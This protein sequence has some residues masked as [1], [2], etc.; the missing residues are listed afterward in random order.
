MHTSIS[1]SLDQAAARAAAL[2]A[3]TFQ[4]FSSS[5]RMWR[6]RVLEPEEIR[7]LRQLR[8]RLELDPFVIHDNYLINLAAADPRIRERS[9]EAF[10]GELE[11]ALAL[12]A[13]YLVLHP[14]SYRGQSLDA[15]LRTL[16]ESLK[17]AARGLR[18]G[19]LTLLVENTA[20][21]G[22]ALGSRFEEL[23]E[24][25]RL[26][27]DLDFPIG[28]C[29]DTAHCLAAGYDVATQA[30]LRS[31]L[32]QA[33]AILGLERIPVIHANDSK[34]PLGARVDR[35]QHIGKGYIGIQGFR[36]ILNHPRL[37]SKAFILETPIDRDG[38][39]RRNLETLKNLC[40][41]SRTTT[42]GSS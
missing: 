24:I 30:G 13:D 12:G 19:G 29:V 27:T 3:N 28:Y 11:R 18:N 10:R 9:I 21:S 31:T 1:G 4:I 40:R 26:T 7:R 20:G 6:A 36:R 15:A 42:T 35:H 17:A 25:R 34:A 37:R 2:G 41:K 8:E 14:G 5:P 22:S 33:Q 16:A 23:A 38:D 32:R 39:D